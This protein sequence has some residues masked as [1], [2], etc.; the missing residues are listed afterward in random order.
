MSCVRHAYEHA[1]DY[2]P[3][4]L[5]GTPVHVSSDG[6]PGISCTHVMKRCLLLAFVERMLYPWRGEREL[7][8]SHL[9]RKRKQKRNDHTNIIT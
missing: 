7:V 9:S 8:I 3:S 6:F 2:E 1:E 4:L 5:I